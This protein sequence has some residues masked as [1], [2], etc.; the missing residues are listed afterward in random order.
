MT[1]SIYNV[2]PITVVIVY[3]RLVVQANLTSSTVFKEVIP[4]SKGL[5]L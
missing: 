3:N 1:L 5:S 4:I 2:F